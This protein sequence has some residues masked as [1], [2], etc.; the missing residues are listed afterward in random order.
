M[1]EE[2]AKAVKSQGAG[3]PEASKADTTTQTAV[4][5]DP[6]VGSKEY[7]FREMERQLREQRQYNKDLVEA[8]KG[9]TQPQ[10]EQQ[11]EDETLPK[12]SPDDIPEWKH[13]EKALGAIQR[14]ATRAAK[15]EAHK[16]VAEKEKARLPELVRQRHQD[17]DAVVTADRI[18][19]LEQENPALAQAFSLAADPFTATYSYFKALYAQQKAD[20]VALEEAEKIMEND[21]KPV[22]SNAIGSGGALKNA[23]AFAK[24]SK[25]QLYKE[26]TGH[27]N[28]VN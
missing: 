2:Q 1:T 8:L 22:S 10:P 12:L 19:K 26:M 20:P 24:K 3:A 4:V 25:E 9:K 5:Q 28:R 6:V 11:Q 23:A 17:F 15:E 13:V 7:N 14:N 16:I 27:A 21:K 18:Q